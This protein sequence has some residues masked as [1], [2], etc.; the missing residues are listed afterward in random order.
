MG[1]KTA[2]KPP[3]KPPKRYS[4]DPSERAKEL[5]AEGRFGG[6][7]EGA[8]RPRKVSPESQSARPAAAHIAAGVAELGPQMLGVI[9]D[10]LEDEEASEGAKLRAL[11]A[12]VGVESKE[13]ELQLVESQLGRPTQTPEFDT[14]EESVSALV[15]KMR[16]NP[17]LAQQMRAVL[18]AAELPE[19]NPPD[20]E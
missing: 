10:V 14:R 15:S 3:L 8:G 13:A 5:V 18:S 1:A 12:A 6:K 2:K 7:R 19:G 11:K 20:S 4:S 16:A 17:L 9:R